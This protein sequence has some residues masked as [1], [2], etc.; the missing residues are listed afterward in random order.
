MPNIYRQRIVDQKDLF[1]ELIVLCEM[2]IDKKNEI[3]KK[4]PEGDLIT[5]NKEKKLSI[6]DPFG[7]L[8]IFLVQMRM[9]YNN[10]IQQLADS[11][12]IEEVEVERNNPEIPE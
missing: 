5:V 11:N 1:A 12:K 10:R 2:A 4:I 7:L 3:L 8:D 6:Q 9:E